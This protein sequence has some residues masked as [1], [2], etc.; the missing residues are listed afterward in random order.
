MSESLL[1]RTELL[2]LLGV[3]ERD[4]DKACKYPVTI[5][6]A[7]YTKMYTR[8]GIAKRV[9]KIEPEE[10]WKVVPEVMENEAES[11][12][13]FEKAWEELLAEHKIWNYL[14]RLDMVSGIGRYGGMLIGV[15]DG[16]MLSDPVELTDGDTTPK[17]KLLFLRPL[18]EANLTIK[19]VETD[20]ASNRYSMPTLYEIKEPSA[21]GMG[22]TTLVHWTRIHHQADNVDLSDMFGAPR[23]Q[24]VY[25]YLENIRKVDGGSGE[26]F[27]LGGFP[28]FSFEANEPNA[29]IDDDSV[30]DQVEAYS[31][32]FQRYLNMVGGTVKSLEPQVADPTPHIMINIKLIA[33]ARGIP[34][35][36]FIGT[37]E[38]KLSSTQDRQ[39]WNDRTAG[40][41]KL[42]LTPC[43]IEPFINRLIQLS[44]LPTCKTLIVSWPKM[45]TLNES[46]N[47]EVTAKLISAI[48]DYILSGAETIIPVFHFL[49]IFLGLTD[50]QALAIIDAA[51]AQ[52]IGEPDDDIDS[53]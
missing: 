21:I 47:A 17:N 40:R 33:A 43:M 3:G 24:S 25:N 34:Y 22:K 36:I 38:S 10:C 6:P 49:T 53:E 48:K 20:I 15:D 7:Q 41:Q 16:G 32:G 18:D 23:M 19:D 30:K 39:M 1:R 11:E 35:R 9:V 29:I 28:G 4:I 27:W 26:M 13:P 52:A 31:E 46:D 14:K 2:N 45:S 8:E 51:E 44:I 37:E 12:T 5:T 50:D 42:Y